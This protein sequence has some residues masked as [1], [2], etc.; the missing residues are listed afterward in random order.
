MKMDTSLLTLSSI[1]KI[2]F[3]LL[4]FSF[5]LFVNFPIIAFDMMYFEQPILYLVNQKITSAGD[6]LNLYLHPTL[7][8]S[9]YIPFFRPSGHFLLYQL[10]MP[11]L[12]WHNTKGL[13]VVN[14]FFLTLSCV[15]IIKLYSLLF[16]RYKVGAYIAIAICLMH[17]AF[18]LIRFIS[19]HF[20]FASIFFLL[21]ALY[22]FLFFCQKNSVLGQSQKIV[23][24][25]SPLTH[26]YLIALVL[27]FYFIAIT[28]K[29]TT[30]M[31]GPVLLGY[32]CI[33]LYQ[34]PLSQFIFSL[35]KHK[36]ALQIIILFSIVSLTYAIY[37]T[38][39]WH[40][41]THPL[42][43]HL[44]I[45]DYFIISKNLLKILFAYPEHIIPKV[46]IHE[47]STLWAT[48]HIFPIANA[49]VMWIFA[50]LLLVSLFLI[51]IA[52]PSE[53]KS[54]LLK[55]IL[56]LYSCCFLFLILP[57]VWA[58]AMAWHTGLTLV[59]L[60]M[61]MGFSVEYVLK[62]IVKQ[63]WVN[64]IG[65]VF[66]ILLGLST[67]IV[68]QTNIAFLKKDS[69]SFGLVLD[70]NAVLHAPEIKHQLNNDSV[71]VVEDSALLHNDYIL[72]NSVYPYML[73][74]NADFH[75]V[76][77]KTTSVYHYPYVYG[78]TLFR[79]AYLMPTLKE[80]VY[81]FQVHRMSDIPDVEIIYNWL[82]HYNNI[83]CLGYDSQGNWHD[84]TVIF[85]K[86]LLQE[87]KRRHLTVNTYH[88]LTRTALAGKLLY[89]TRIP[90]PDSMLCKFICDKNKNCKG[91]TYINVKV[92]DNYATQCNFY[93]KIFSHRKACSVC[94]GFV[95]GIRV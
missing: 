39:P 9:F 89:N 87:K 11:F 49:F 31:L 24:T 7:L 45:E 85:K 36:Q 64:I 82:Q 28:F 72:G 70:R 78:G 37:L 18:T 75:R 17:P 74:G 22:C 38:L 67:I 63:P 50:A 56:F 47:N 51:Y 95:K 91:L 19:L 94:M 41:L 29:E 88:L 15:M 62:H 53:E 90:I 35:L 25:E 1:K 46:A 58:H 34:P 48:V 21:L 8:D 61:L 6:L 40:G 12:G 3:F 73:L 10:L 14:F 16:P 26:F 60:S 80:Q 93:S 81:P 27:V 69:R 33:A 57:I 84:R 20:E 44:T 4:L 79:W 83:F 30:I 65:A 13:L 42:L 5:V 32:F 71:V 2:I 55:S 59:F 23:L 77:Q 86:N 68:N 43:G 76:I 52:K 66:A 92:H 54:A